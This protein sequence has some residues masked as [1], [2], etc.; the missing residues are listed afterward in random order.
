MVVQFTMVDLEQKYDTIY[1]YAGWKSTG[2]TP[3]K[4]TTGLMNAG[5][6]IRIPGNTV[7]FKFWSD[8]LVVGKG[9][10][11]KY[12]SV[13][14]PLKVNAGNDT[15]LCYGDSMQLKAAVGG[16]YTPD[17]RVTWKGWPSG[18]SPYVKPTDTATYTV[19]LYDVCSGFSVSDQIK[20]GV[21]QPLQLAAMK[22]TVICSGT[23]AALRASV[24][25]GLSL[26]RKL[27]WTPGNLNGSPAAAKPAAT[28]T[29]MAVLSD[30]C[31]DVQDTA[32]VK[33]WVKTPLKVKLQTVDTLL[34]AK[35]SVRLTAVASGGDTLKHQLLWNRGLGNGSFKKTKPSADGW[36]KVTLSDGC[37]APGNSDSV[38]VRYRPALN[39][40]LDPDTLICAGR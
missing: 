32:F 1:L 23:T 18:V 13:R 25:G 2:A 10:K 24:S 16:G 11:A 6:P 8:Q 5:L 4:T 22:D 27:T 3:W 37:S 17:L 12:Y 7:T 33:V 21:L 38:Y 39:I 20:V 15:T 40:R 29:Y 28:T 34:C 26:T 9:F 14:K 36:Y 31:T 30:G 35:D 19:T